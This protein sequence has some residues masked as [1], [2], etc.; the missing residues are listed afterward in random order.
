MF[1]VKQRADKK[2]KIDT[3]FPPSLSLSLSLFI[4]SL[5]AAAVFI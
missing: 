5:D 3:R 1:L 2:T 4:F